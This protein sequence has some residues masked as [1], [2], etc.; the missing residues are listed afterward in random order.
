M[1]KRFDGPV[2]CI[3]RI[4]VVF[5]SNLVARQD[6]QPEQHSH[7]LYD[8]PYVDLPLT[9]PNQSVRSTH[10]DYHLQTDDRSLS[11]YGER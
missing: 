6:F 3:V 5:C 1:L 9:V 10:P 7:N 2:L 8:L 11:L 4:H